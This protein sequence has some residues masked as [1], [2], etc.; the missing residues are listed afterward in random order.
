MKSCAAAG[1]P[2]KGQRKC[3]KADWVLG[4]E[5][6]TG[7]QR[8]A[9]VDFSPELTQRSS[10]GLIDIKRREALGNLSKNIC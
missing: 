4:L 3:C 1:H 9:E 8:E 7:R 5:G 6:G 2:G 10:R